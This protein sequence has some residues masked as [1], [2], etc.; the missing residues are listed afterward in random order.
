[1]QCSN[2]INVADWPILLR[3]IQDD[4]EKSACGIINP[5]LGGSTLRNYTRTHSV[6]LGHIHESLVSWVVSVDVPLR[7][8]ASEATVLTRP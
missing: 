1:M 6:H 8:L 4:T 2:I 7:F 5:S 3:D